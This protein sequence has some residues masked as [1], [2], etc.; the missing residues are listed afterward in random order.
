M[1]FK[2]R[3]QLPKNIDIM[4]CNFVLL[5]G[6]LFSK[7]IASGYHSNLQHPEKSSKNT[8]KTGKSDEK[9]YVHASSLPRKSYLKKSH[10]W[11]RKY[12]W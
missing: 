7:I 5:T 12:F 6:V 4:H 3:T 8:K 2:L 1:Q 11:P 10:C 9:I